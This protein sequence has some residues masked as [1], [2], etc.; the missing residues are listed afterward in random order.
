[1]PPRFIKK[2]GGYRRKRR[3]QKRRA[4]VRKR[5]SGPM[6]RAPRTYQFSREIW[7]TINLANTT[8]TLM[9][10]PT[11]WNSALLAAGNRVNF[12]PR[13]TL[14]EL[15][16]Y[17]EFTNLFGQYR[18]RAMSITFYPAYTTSSATAAA[19]YNPVSLMLFTKQNQTGKPET[20]LTEVQW[21]EIVRKRTRIF[22][23]SQKPTSFY[24]GTRQVS[25]VADIEGALTSSVISMPRWQSTLEPDA[26]HITL[27][28]SLATMDNST[29][30][31]W[32]GAPGRMVFKMRTKIFLETRYVK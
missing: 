31:S 24:I 14:A 16:G 30:L 2:T 21:A 5:Y 12:Q 20:A 13:I 32:A 7:N 26:Q 10:F 17:T 8:P 23:P 15:P 27:T 9:G 28:C 6:A 11:I 29:L 25:S 4:L 19:L 1:M 22:C 18:I 3:P